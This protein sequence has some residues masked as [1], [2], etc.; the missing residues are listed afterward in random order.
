MKNILG[1]KKL[2]NFE[3][4][5]ILKQ[6]IQ[7]YKNFRKYLTTSKNIPSQDKCYKDS[8]KKRL[9]ISHNKGSENIIK[10]VMNQDESNRHYMDNALLE[11]KIFIKKEINK[12]KYELCSWQLKLNN[13]NRS[14][15]F[16]PHNKVANHG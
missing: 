5:K 10:K 1:N 12:L 8:A 11:I 7:I 9:K 14:V 13:A 4:K 16:K 3:K 6:E 15:P 2:S